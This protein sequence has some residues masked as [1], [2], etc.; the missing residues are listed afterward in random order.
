MDAL[1]GCIFIVDTE[2]EKI[3]KM[4]EARILNIPI[5][6]MVDTNYDPVDYV[7]PSND[8]A[9]VQ[10]N[11]ISDIMAKC[12]YWRKRTCHRGEKHWR[13]KTATTAEE[14]TEDFEAN[15]LQQK[16]KVE[17]DVPELAETEQ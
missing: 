5:V 11:L 12:R 13:R 9:A 8:D 3:A 15:W 14:E 2:Y 10:A 6:A 16:K 17:F 1:P 7:I 4:H